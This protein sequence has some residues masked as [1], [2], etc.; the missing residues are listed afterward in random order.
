MKRVNVTSWE[1]ENAAR[2]ANV[3]P[4]S[5]PTFPHSHVPTFRRAFSL[6]EMMIALAILAMGLLVIGAALPIGIRYTRASINIATGEAAAEYALDLIEQ[7]VCIPRDIW[8]DA[9]A[10][11][12]RETGL[13]VPRYW[14]PLPPPPLPADPNGAFDGNYEPL[15]KVR[16]LFTR[17]IVTSTRDEWVFSNPVPEQLAA[18][19]ATSQQQVIIDPTREFDNWVWMQPSVPSVSLFYPPST[20][21]VIYDPNVYF[22]GAPVDYT[23]R[24][25][26]SPGTNPAGAETTKAAAQRVVWTAFYRR[27]SYGEDAD[28]F[29]YEFIAVAVRTPSANHRFPMQDPANGGYLQGNDV[30]IPVPWMV[31]FDSL[32]TVDPSLYASLSPEERYLLSGFAPPA[33]IA[34][35]TTE[36]YGRMLPAGSLLIPAVNDWKP[37]A[38][39]A[40]PPTNRYGFVPSTPSTLPI[41]EVMERVEKSDGST[42]VLVKSNGFYPWVVDPSL[43]AQ[44]PFWVIPP[45]FE[46][47]DGG[48][49]PV[50]PDRS[51]IVAVARRYVRLRE[52]P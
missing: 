5:V 40:F 41:Y 13:F 12:T 16:P 30:A 24:P 51:P 8:D 31:F 46:E 7:N 44:F 22:T 39:Q 3:P 48:G 18:A 23:P 27:V 6:A 20:A 9:N 26:R 11:Q 15:I 34:F 50:F 36:A 32:P 14:P 43:I 2:R 42:D 21:D 28:P 25:V 29:A 10:V 1:S 45:A 37:N 33:T 52:V 49:Q 17:N 4:L 38:L 19:W 35:T 47:L